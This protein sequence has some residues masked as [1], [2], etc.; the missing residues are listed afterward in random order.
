[1]KAV[2]DRAEAGVMP[3]VDRGCVRFGCEHARREKKMTAP[4]QPT[5]KPRIVCG[6]TPSSASDALLRAAVA[7]CR[8][9][10][11]QLVT[12][13]IVDPASFRSPMAVAGGLGV[14]G[15]VGA[16][17][18]TLERARREGLV[19]DTVFRVGEPTRVLEEERKASGA[20]M[21][22]TAAD[23]PVR[24]CPLCGWREDGRATHFCPERHL[25]R[26]PAARAQR[27]S[28]RLKSSPA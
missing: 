23:V 20:E 27:R 12:V 6:L 24:R 1:M 9:H 2:V 17:S 22:F 13:W 21:V 5:T 18:G 28:A 19:A 26:T 25:P 16:W 4:H 15:L 11:F 3:A 8:E 14:W 7:H 10:G